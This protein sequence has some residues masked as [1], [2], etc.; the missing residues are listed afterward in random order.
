M[1]LLDRFKAGDRRALAKL[2]TLVENSVDETNEI[3]SQI[4]PLIGNA[5]ILGITGPPGAGK[6]TLADN[7]LSFWRKEEHKIGAVLID[8]SSPFTGGALLGDRIRMQRHAIDEGV[9]IRSLGSRGSH[10]GLS[11]ATRQ[12]VQLLDAFGFDIIIIETVGVGQTELDIMELADTTIVILGPESGDT[13]QTMKAGLMEIADIF[14]VNK[15]DREGASRMVTEITSMLELKENAKGQWKP[16]VLSCQANKGVGIEEIT[17][18]VQEHREHLE[19]NN[20]REEHRRVIRRGELTEII[21]ERVRSQITK[22]ANDGELKRF[23]E[24]VEKNR[25][26]PYSAAKKIVNSNIIGNVLKRNEG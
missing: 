14:V 17:K 2:I 12:V 16:P 19:K 5:Y 20:L 9:Y 21:L 13:V 18:A 4:Y 7:L 8:P 22:S 3:M 26:N 24:D 6:S 10:G 25:E 1:E 15:A 11:R 23:F